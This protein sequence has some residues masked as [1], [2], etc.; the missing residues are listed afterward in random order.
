M[1][2]PEKLFP[3]GQGQ[4]QAADPDKETIDEQLPMVI[5]DY[6]A[7]FGEVEKQRAAHDTEAQYRAE[8]RGT[9]YQ[10]KNRGNQFD[11]ARPDAPPGLHPNGRK[12]VDGLFGRAEFKEQRLQ[13]DDRRQDTQY[14]EK[15]RN[16][17]DS[18]NDGVLGLILVFYCR[19]LFVGGSDH[20]LLVLDP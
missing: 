2:A 10:Q 17:L 20:L 14:P 19:P 8:S 4:D 16:A 13:Q 12:N 1:E 3:E 18:H 9:G 6:K 7:Q 15:D 11:D 5:L